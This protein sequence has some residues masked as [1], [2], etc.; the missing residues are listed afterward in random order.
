[1]GG[2]G[3]FPFCPVLEPILFLLYYVLRIYL[4]NIVTLSIVC[5]SIYLLYCTVQEE[6]SKYSEI[7]G[8]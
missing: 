2:C 1:M 6:T 3:D 8:E 4:N 7:S 5:M